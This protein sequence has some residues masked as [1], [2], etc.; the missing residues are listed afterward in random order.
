MNYFCFLPCQLPA[1]RLQIVLPTW[2]W[3]IWQRQFEN[4]INKT[5]FKTNV[6][7]FL[8]LN[9]SLQSITRAPAGCRAGTCFDWL[10]KKDWLCW[11]LS[12]L[13]HWGYFWKPWRGYHSNGCRCLKGVTVS[14]LSYVSQCT[15]IKQNVKNMPILTNLNRR[16]VIEPSIWLHH[17]WE[18]Y[19]CR[20]AHLHSWATILRNC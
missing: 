3:K 20:F 1:V 15:L 6:V 19:L 5:E 12:L 16:F 18:A 2:E 11:W 10:W 4:K 8:L 7:H 14:A 17:V 13:L 9:I